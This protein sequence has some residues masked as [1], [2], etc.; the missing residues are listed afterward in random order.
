MKQLRRIFTAL[1]L[2]TMTAVAITM[3][4]TSAVQRA[5]SYAQIVDQWREHWPLSRGRGLPVRLSPALD[6][7]G[8]VQPVR[9]EM[10]PQVS[11][12]LNPVDLVDR[13]LLLRGK[14]Q[15]S[16]WEMVSSHL[17]PSGVFVDVGAHI[18]IFSL[19]AAKQMGAQ[20]QVIAV[21]PNPRTAQRLRDN[22]EASGWTNIRVEEVACGASLGKATLFAGG[23]D[24]SGVASLAESNAVMNGGTGRISY[25]VDI[26]TLDHLVKG[27]ALTRLD[28]IKIDTEGAETQILRGAAE[29]LRRF[30]PAIVLETNGQQ[31]ENMNSSI[32]E[33]EALLSSYGYTKGRQG[34]SDVEWLP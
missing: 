32:E 24:N 29:T 15:D 34:S 7:L 6:A 1:L 11:L 5:T 21:E 28:A 33:L 10:E 27:T 25:E 31:L 14:W 23:L 16:V 3:I 19:R 18:G 30:R 13:R 8:I 12:L 9:V 20:G 26:V 2:V 22:V 4:V 17:P